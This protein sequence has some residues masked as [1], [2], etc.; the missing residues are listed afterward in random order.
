MT[1]STGTGQEGGGGDA[2]KREKVWEYGQGKLEE[3]RKGDG[4]GRYW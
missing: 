3:E 2:S 4:L 1:P